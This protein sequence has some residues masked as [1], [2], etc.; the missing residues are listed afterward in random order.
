MNLQHALFRYRRLSL[1]VCLLALAT[2]LVAIEVPSEVDLGQVEPGSTRGGEFRVTNTGAD[3]VEVSLLSSDPAL[4]LSETE[5]VLR[6][7]D[8]LDI[9]FEL[10]IPDRLTGELI[11]IVTVL[12]EQADPSEALAVV[13]RGRGPAP[14]DVS[15]PEN[16][17]HI[18][19]YMDVTCP[20]CRAIVEETI[21]AAFGETPYAL[22]ELDVLGPAN[23]DALLERLEA[24]GEPL[25][26]LP[27]A[28]VDM[29][30][31]AASPQAQAEAS[32]QAQRLPTDSC[33]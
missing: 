20:K 14:P 15:I 30:S 6:A 18:D 27:V 22:R 3:L 17:P 13:I 19:I 5:F 9:S 32:Q 2:A 11:R 1:L 10:L 31:L 25:V 7:N 23:M 28:F 24:R 12:E 21:P 16:A 8:S 33:L 29:R 26:E 4:V